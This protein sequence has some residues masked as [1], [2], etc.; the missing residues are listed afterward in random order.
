[1][2]EG[3]RS[4]RDIFWENILFLIITH[5]LAALSILYAI[6]IKFSWATIGLSVT[7]LVLC[8]LAVSG[9]YHRL[10][11]H[12]AYKCSKIV[13]VFHLLF[14]AG[15]W[16]ESALKWAT[17][18]RNHHAYVDQEGDPYNITKGFWWAHLGWLCYRNANP[19]EI[20]YPKDLQENRL[21]ALQDRYYLILA[22]VMGALVPTLIAA[23]WG[24]AMGGFLM[25]GWLRLLI[26]YHSA[27]AVNS[28][29]HY[30]G[31]RPYSKT[32]SARETWPLILCNLILL[33]TMGEGFYHNY[34]HR[35]PS[36]YRNGRRFYHYDPVKWMVWF[37]SKLGLAWDLKTVPEH[38][39]EKAQDEM[40]RKEEQIPE[41]NT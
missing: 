11:S 31:M 1:M 17:N 34:H 19:E 10:W 28:V 20:K 35:F 33:P 22:L 32:N 26:Q 25:A 15:S 12:R 30:F 23:S 40:R 16:Q 7:W 14:G 38:A 29:S 9:G 36:D 5:V 27:F 2:A 21:I 37:L 39:I 13:E 4:W 18:H 8:A 24:D 6:H 3:K 41:F